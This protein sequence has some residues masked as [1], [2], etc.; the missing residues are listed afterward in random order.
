[1]LNPPDKKKPHWRGF[2]T[3][4]IGVVVAWISFIVGYETAL[5]I[6]NPTS[7][8]IVDVRAYDSVLEADDL[9]VVVEYNLPYAVIPD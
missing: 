4:C 9:L 1:M 8:T 6:S 7:I 3:L 5:G 2:F